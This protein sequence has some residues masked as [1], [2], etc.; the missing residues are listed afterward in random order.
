MESEVLRTRV[1]ARWVVGGGKRDRKPS[2]CGW[3]AKEESRL[4]VRLIY[5]DAGLIYRDEIKA[6]W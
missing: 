1:K 3:I 5:E 6:N 4:E 2:W